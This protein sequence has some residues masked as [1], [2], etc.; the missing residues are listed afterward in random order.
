MPTDDQLARVCVSPLL[1]DDVGD[2]SA[3]RTLYTDAGIQSE[4]KTPV[5]LLDLPTLDLR[6]QVTL[7]SDDLLCQVMPF[8]QVWAMIQS[9]ARGRWA[10]VEA[11][12][13]HPN[14]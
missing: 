12:S 6:R 10:R 7:N 14:I 11:T 8:G 4:Q 9:P 5:H 3:V 1:L 2:R 13:R